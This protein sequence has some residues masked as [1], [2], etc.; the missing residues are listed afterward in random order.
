CFVEALSRSPVLYQVR[1]TFANDAEINRRH[2]TQFGISALVRGNEPE[3]RPVAP[4][5]RRP[6]T[7]RTEEKAE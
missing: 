5:K 2:V 3:S 1:L 6:T 7:T 4:S